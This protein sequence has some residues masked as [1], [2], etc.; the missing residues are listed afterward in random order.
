M[1]SELGHLKLMVHALQE[2]LARKEQETEEE[3]RQATSYYNALEV[4]VTVK[5]LF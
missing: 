1:R 2:Q 3:Q 5:K 4:S